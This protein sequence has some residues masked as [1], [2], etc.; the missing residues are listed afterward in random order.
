ML[1]KLNKINEIQIAK[2]I[3]KILNAELI[4]SKML[5]QVSFFKKNIFG[6]NQKAL[7]HFYNIELLINL[8][9]DIIMSAKKDLKKRKF[10]MIKCQCCGK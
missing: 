4:I 6:T 7:K 5:T 10:K 9:Y 8:F 2:D 1:K 3:E